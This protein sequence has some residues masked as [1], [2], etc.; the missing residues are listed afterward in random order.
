VDDGA[1]EAF[2]P[3]SEQHDIAAAVLYER[4]AGH[5]GRAER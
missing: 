1:V 3:L 4:A 2:G 5:H